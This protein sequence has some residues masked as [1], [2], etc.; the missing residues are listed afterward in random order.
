MEILIGLD[1]YSSAQHIQIFVYFG[2]SRLH[3]ITLDRQV[4]SYML[5]H[6][7]ALA[8]AGSVVFSPSAISIGWTRV[9]LASA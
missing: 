3:P 6:L 8:S 1:H 9:Q 2:G 4:F 7:I 5:G